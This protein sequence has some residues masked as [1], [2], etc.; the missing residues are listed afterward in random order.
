MPRTAKGSAPAL[1]GP[2]ARA[3]VDVLA[4]PV[5]IVDADGRILAVNA[6]WRVFARK[7]RGALVAV[8]EGANYLAVCD[9]AS[10]RKSPGAAEVAAGIR[11][12][13]QGKL[14]EF[15]AEYPCHS[16]TEERWFI[17]RVTRFPGE[18]PSRAASAHEDITEPGLAVCGTCGTAEEALTA[19][20]KL[21]PDIVV[22][23]WNLPG[24][25]GL[26]LLKDLT[27]LHPGL[28]VLVLSM[29]DEE[30]YAERCLHA[31]ARGYV[32]KNEG[33]EKLVAGIRSVLA[34]GI[35]VSARTSA[36]IVASFSGQRTR[37]KA[38]PLGGLTDR[39]FEVF[40]WIG[41]GLSTQAIADRLHISVKTIETHRI[42]LK[43]KLG[44]AT[45]AE[46]VAYA[47]RWVAAK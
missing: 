25:S 5:A 27:A 36:R 13:L 10:R 7:N 15:A 8:G 32:M 1:D 33:P 43:R 19:V 6:R 24:K 39:E 34:G 30:I 16:P 38:S 46:L 28:A 20:G 2:T 44:L 11:S 40:Q 9:R 14:P 4:A 37:E 26:E 42:H 47:A 41:G 35:H 22:T 17:V 23:D 3:L 45:A 18:G 29:H 31:G 21:R 12:V